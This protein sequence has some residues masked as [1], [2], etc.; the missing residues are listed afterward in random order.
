MRFQSSSSTTVTV[1]EDAD[2]VPSSEDPMPVP[3]TTPASPGVE[4]E[5]DTMRL[6]LF[7][8]SNS[9]DTD[10]SVMLLKRMGDNRQRKLRLVHLYS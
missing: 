1:A 9:E 4:E 3:T 7:D 8:V 6:A 5:R 10:K 2:P